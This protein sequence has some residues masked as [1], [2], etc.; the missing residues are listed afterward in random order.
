MARSESERA[1]ATAPENDAGQ[2]NITNPPNAAGVLSAT[3]AT[4]PAVAQLEEPVAD[5][6]KS[7]VIVELASNPVRNPAA[8]LTRAVVCR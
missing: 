2:Q 7:D 3:A 4:G 6:G 5:S 1:K 8:C